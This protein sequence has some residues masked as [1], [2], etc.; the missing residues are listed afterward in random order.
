HRR[1]AKVCRLYGL[2]DPGRRVKEPEAVVLLI[3]QLPD[4]AD[5][6][7][8][9]IAED[10]RRTGESGCLDYRPCDAESGVRDP[11]QYLSDAGPLRAPGDNR[12]YD[13]WASSVS[14]G[15]EHGTVK[16]WCDPGTG[17][18]FVDAQSDVVGLPAFEFDR[19]GACRDLVLEPTRL[20]VHEPT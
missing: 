11:L 17:L 15:M 13:D 8:T 20:L 19:Q 9:G 16:H 14:P 12:L 4:A 6:G 10:S 1:T 2:F 18:Q 3:Q 5:K 7:R